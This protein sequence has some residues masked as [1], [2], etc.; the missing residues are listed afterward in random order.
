MLLPSEIDQFIK[1]APEND[2]SSLKDYYNKCYDNLKDLNA[3]SNKISV[4][5]LLLLS[6]Y[7]FSSYIKDAEF[8]GAKV[9][10]L[11]LIGR[12][13][14]LLFSYF[15]LEWCL[16][17]KRRRGLMVIM[18]PLSS[19]IFGFSRSDAESLFTKFSEHS[20]NVMPFSFMI[21]ILNINHQTRFSRMMFKIFFIFSF[22]GIPFF[23]LSISVYSAFIADFSIPFLICNLISMYCLSWVVYF[24]ITDFG[25]VYN[26]MVPNKE[27]SKRAFYKKYFQNIFAIW[28]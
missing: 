27:T 28:R 12:L 9:T 16:L 18:K 10:D 26:N 8:L 21:E 25:L 15:L 2:Q 23:I 7:A 24:Y 19:K 3:R 17:A 4:F 22:L 20:L 6:F 11:Q 13:T 14:P 1:S 5:L